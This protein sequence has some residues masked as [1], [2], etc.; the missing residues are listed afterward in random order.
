MRILRQRRDH[1]R[2]SARRSDA[3]PQRRTNP[4]GALDRPVSMRRTPPDGGSHQA[5]RAGAAADKEDGTKSNLSSDARAAL[6]KAGITRRDFVKR[7]GILIVAFSGGRARA[8][9]ALPRT[10]FRPKGSMVPVT[11]SSTRGL[12]LVPMGA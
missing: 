6:A 2:E 9:S 11:R 8:I 10:L 1:D 5:L 7:S 4:T 12:R 3:Q